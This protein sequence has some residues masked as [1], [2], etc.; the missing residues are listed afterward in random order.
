MGI[1]SAHAG[2][3]STNVVLDPVLQHMPNSNPGAIQL[4]VACIKACLSGAGEHQCILQLCKGCPSGDD[5][6]EMRLKLLSQ[7]SEVYPYTEDD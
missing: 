5:V 4:K 7:K 2:S 1:Y 6:S 3:L